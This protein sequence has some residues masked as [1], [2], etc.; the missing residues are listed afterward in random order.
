MKHYIYDPAA[1]EVLGKDGSPITGYEPGLTNEKVLD[2]QPFSR[3]TVM[4]VCTNGELATITVPGK[5]EGLTVQQVQE[6]VRNL[7]FI[8]V[9]FSGLTLEE[10]G[11]SYNKLTRTGMAEKATI[12]TPIPTPS[13]S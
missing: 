1:T 2:G 8:K 4:A 7:T 9:K 5:V 13:K 10:K 12:V 6:S 11:D 3:L